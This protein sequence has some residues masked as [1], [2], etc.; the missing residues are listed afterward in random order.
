MV[1][2]E[3]DY[4]EQSKRLEE[5]ENLVSELKDTCKDLNEKVDEYRQEITSLQSQL[6]ELT[7]QSLEKEKE[8]FSAISELTS[9]LEHA[10]LDLQT[11]L[12]QCQQEKHESNV[13]QIQVLKDSV[14]AAERVGAIDIQ[15]LKT[16][17]LD[18]QTLLFETEAEKRALLAKNG[19]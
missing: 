7:M 8:S 10:S 2:L 3:V 14:A 19:N 1:K 15:L 9:K 12:E 13:V 5:K 16:K 6:A 17:V 18:F 11:H 4:S